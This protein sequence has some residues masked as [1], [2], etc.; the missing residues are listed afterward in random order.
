MRP[1]RIHTDPADDTE[2]RPPRPVGR[3]RRPESVRSGSGR[4]LV[5]AGRGVV[6]REAMGLGRVYSTKNLR[7]LFEICD[8]GTRM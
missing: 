7:D 8:R 5:G 3:S 1:S 6:E 2:R 4:A